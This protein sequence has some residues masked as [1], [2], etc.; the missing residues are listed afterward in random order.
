MRI[1]A[2]DDRVLERI[3]KLYAFMVI[4][5]GE[6]NPAIP[7]VT[8][9]AVENALAAMERQPEKSDLR[10]VSEDWCDIDEADW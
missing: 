5:T 2:S 7:G 8:E 3:R 1:G 9:A 4:E 6:E 10:V